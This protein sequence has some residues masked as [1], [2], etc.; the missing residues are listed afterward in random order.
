MMKPHWLRTIRQR[1]LL[2]GNAVM[3]YVT[4]AVTE[5]D[6]PEDFELL[7]FQLARNKSIFTNLFN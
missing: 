6:V 7:E 2:H 1:N 4:P 5:V 3:P